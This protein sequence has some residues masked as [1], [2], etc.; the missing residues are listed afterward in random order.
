[1]PPDQPD[2][3]P[4][5]LSDA[6]PEVPSLWLRQA[7]LPTTIII[8]AAASGAVIAPA[9]AAPY[10][11]PVLGLG[12]TAIG[13]YVALSF[14]SAM[15][16]GLFGAALVR[17]LGPLRCSQIALGVTI[18]GLGAMTVPHLWAAVAGVMLMGIGMGPISPASSD[19]LAR[20]TAPKRMSLVFS[21]KQTGVPLG[22][23]VAGLVVPAGLALGGIPAAFGAMAA[24]CLLGLV[25]AIPLRRSLDSQRDPTAP[26]P[27]MAVVAA[28]VRLVVTHPVLPQ[29]AVCSIIFNSTQ[30]SYTTFLVS[31]LNVDV[32]WTLVAAGAAMSVAQ[33]AG[34]G[35]RVLWGFVAD[36]HPD[37]A[38]RTL[39][40]LALAMVATSIALSLVGA[41]TPRPAMLVL[42]ALHGATAIGWNGVYL[43][44]VARQVPL[45]Q[46]AMA[47]AGCMFFTFMGVVIGPPL[48]GAAASL[49]GS[50]GPAFALPALPLLF[51]AWSIRGARWAVPR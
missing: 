13:A 45:N 24:L 30:V 21:I 37:G 8:Q 3:P 29:L 38:R 44:T 33:A 12:S 20:T 51:L 1:M 18:V 27:T 23:A 15:A 42:L 39:L 7:T 9:V 41:Q 25:M 46:A 31:Y 6:P 22:G 32:G 43:A 26:W 47:T 16:A 34:V 48:F 4:N 14:L 49:F 2:T 17:R 11:L 10:L 19:M 50:Y 5:T 40:G 35:G 28:P 36:R